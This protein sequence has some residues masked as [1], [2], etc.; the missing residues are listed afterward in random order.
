MPAVR[1]P[2]G[3][4]QAR[5]RRDPGADPPL[6]G[7]DLQAAVY[8]RFGDDSL[9]ERGDFGGR[10]SGVQLRC[11]LSVQL[12]AD[13]P[14]WNSYSYQPGWNSYSYKKI[15]RQSGQQM[16]LAGGRLGDALGLGGETLGVSPCES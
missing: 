4:S 16:P 3:A 1:P 10:V 5:A 14:G 12:W 13:Q 9:S 7:A 15:A 2:G 6:V 11:G 8:F